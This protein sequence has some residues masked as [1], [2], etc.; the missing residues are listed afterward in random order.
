ME[1]LYSSLFIMALGVAGCVVYFVGSNW[2]L[3]ILFPTR[4]VSNQKMAQNLRRAA[5][6]RP[7]LFLGPALARFRPLSCLSSI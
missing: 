3:T 5:A 6:I 1:Q 4:N 2:L 7:W